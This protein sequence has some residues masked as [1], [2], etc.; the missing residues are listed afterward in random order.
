MIS[1]VRH[2]LLSRH[3]SYFDVNHSEQQAG[4]ARRHAELEVKRQKMKEKLL[5][6]ENGQANNTA[7]VKKLQEESTMRMAQH[8]LPIGLPKTLSMR[9]DPLTKAQAFLTEMPSIE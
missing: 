6:E 8:N 7:I 3:L 9:D 1:I 5:A 2:S 4:E